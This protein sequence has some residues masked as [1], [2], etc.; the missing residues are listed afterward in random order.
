MPAS[1]KI[2]CARVFQETPGLFTSNF[3]ALL[4]VAAVK[5][6]GE[7]EKMFTTGFQLAIAFS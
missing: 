5:K 1:F 7:G 3:A 6:S 2:S 4:T